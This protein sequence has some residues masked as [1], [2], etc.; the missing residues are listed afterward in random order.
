MSD[1]RLPGHFPLRAF[2]SVNM[3]RRMNK[4]ISRDQALSM[5]GDD[6]REDL[7]NGT[8]K[9]WRVTLDGVEQC[10]MDDLKGVQDLDGFFIEDRNN[11]DLA[12][13][14]RYALGPVIAQRPGERVQVTDYDPKRLL[15]YLEAEGMFDGIDGELMRKVA[16]HVAK[17]GWQE[18][19]MLTFRQT[20]ARI[21]QH[22]EEKGE[23]IEDAWPSVQREVANG[24]LNP[25][26]EVPP[27]NENPA[28]WLREAA[29]GERVLSSREKTPIRNIVR[30]TEQD[31]SQCF[32]L[33]SDSDG[34]TGS[35]KASLASAQNNAEQWIK[36]TARRGGCMGKANYRKA[37]LKEISGLSMRAFDRA[38]GNVTSLP[39][40]EHLTKP[41]TKS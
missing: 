19:K 35:P 33:E 34:M 20:A 32:P 11:P 7:A 14:A 29:D 21:R 26:G 31:V 38:W 27:G 3:I 10:S 17:N 39:E 15:H 25:L 6:L 22:Y 37:A 1:P 9:L 41:G 5:I 13:S 23:T 8:L 30:F 24:A 40:F 4:G 16:E 2:I 28:D 36:E 12:E 18:V